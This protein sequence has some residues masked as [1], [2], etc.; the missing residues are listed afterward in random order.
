LN[1]VTVTEV[2]GEVAAV[3][4]RY[5]EDR[6]AFIP[7]HRM[8]AI[9]LDLG[10]SAEDLESLRYVSDNL[11]EDPTLPFRE[12]RNGRFCLNSGSRRGSRLEF[13]PFV[14]S[15]DEDFVRHDSGQVRRFE[16]IQDELQGNR[17]FQA[18]LQFKYLVINGL[19]T[20]PRPSLDYESDKWICTLF[21][22]RTV[23]T[24][25]LLGEPA[26]E[27]VHSDGVDHTMTTLLG[28]SNMTEDS[29]VTLV[30]EMEEKNSLRW[31]ATDPALV[32]GRWQ[33]KHFL[34]TL[35]LADHERKHSLSP[36]RARE[37]TSRATRDMLVFFTRRP[38][39]AG[40]VSHPYDSLQPHQSLPLSFEL[41]EW[42]DMASTPA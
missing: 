18:L 9:V 4:H 23:T 28:S 35:L 30:H 13:Q 27:G 11:S 24:P 20:V 38:A 1:P 22:L 26:L 8:S 32:A 15:T 31:D 29:A 36:V 17:A 2:L 3:R 19:K 16:E 40:H 33:H 21:N 25:T 41:L 39:L 5:A 42:D 34:D 7:G 6:V 14:L 37:T 12:S 10:G